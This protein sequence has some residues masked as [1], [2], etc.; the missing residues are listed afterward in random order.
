MQSVMAPG[1]SATLCQY[2]GS[3]P[4][5]PCTRAEAIPCHLPQDPTGILPSISNVCGTINLLCIGSF[6]QCLLLSCIVSSYTLSII[7][8]ILCHVSSLIFQGSFLW[9][10]HLWLS[11][12]SPA[13]TRLIP[14]FILSIVINLSPPHLSVLSLTQWS[15]PLSVE[16][17]FNHFCFSILDCWSYQ[18]NFHKTPIHLCKVPS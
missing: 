5:P 1:S 7:P 9:Y 8:T 2:W 17:C 12:V 11:A 14:P 16:S 10:T 15:S 6:Q 13:L 3:C 4:T 18:C